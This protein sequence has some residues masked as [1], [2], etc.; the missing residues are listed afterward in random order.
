M[1]SLLLLLFVFCYFM[2]SAQIEKR[3]FDYKD[4]FDLQYASNPKISPNGKQIVYSKNSFDIM[5]DRKVSELWIINADG[6]GNRKLT[7]LENGESQAS[8]SHDGSRIAFSSSTTGGAE[9]HVL[10]MESGVVASISQLEYSPSSIMWSP[11]DEYL[12]FKMFVSTS[13]PKIDVEKVSPPKGAEW[14][15]KPRL[16]TRLNHEADGRG[17][18]KDGFTHIFLIPS[19]GGKV[20]QCTTGEYNHSGGMSW[21]KDNKHIVFS[22]NREQDRVY[23]FRN[24]NIYKVN[25]ESQEVTQLSANFGPESNPKVSPDGKFIAYTGLDDEIRTCL[26]YTSPSPRD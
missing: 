2:S 3:P 6:S 24:S 18:L 26:L 5:K 15:K 11:N 8:W 22:A 25:V 20:R 14:S 16:T 9:I 17:Y 7:N 1:R 19:E 12:A 13:G 21:L 4:V 23:Q 10:W